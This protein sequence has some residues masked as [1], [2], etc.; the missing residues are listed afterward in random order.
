MSKPIWYQVQNPN[1]TARADPTTVGRWHFRIVWRYL[2]D[3]HRTN[4]HRGSHL[5]DQPRLFV[6]ASPIACSYPHDIRRLIPWRAYAAKFELEMGIWY[7]GCDHAILRN[8]DH[9]H[10]DL[11]AK[12]SAKARYREPETVA[13]E[14]RWCATWC[15]VEDTDLSD[16]LGAPRYH[17]SFPLD[18][19]AG[20]D[21]ATLV[22]Y[23]K[24]QHRTLE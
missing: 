18:G 24:T 15:T 6:Y 4:L 12:K 20:D 10:H 22:H 8:P 2:V 13:P 11:Y 23:W 16:C 19:R 3:H 21:T 14:S 1:E 17:G 9:R 5:A 7:V